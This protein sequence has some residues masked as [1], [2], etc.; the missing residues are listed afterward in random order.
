[1]LRNLSAQLEEYKE[2]YP[3]ICAV[4]FD[5]ESKNLTTDINEYVD[6]YKRN[7]G[8]HSIVLRGKKR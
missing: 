7:Y 6:K 4:I 5:D 1:M 2:E 3:N 8:I